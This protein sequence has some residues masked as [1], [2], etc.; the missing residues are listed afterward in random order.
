M[1]GHP[2]A[3]ETATWREA[4]LRVISKVGK[5][6]FC[7]DDLYAS[8]DDLSHLFPSNMNLEAKVRQQ[9]Q[10][11]RDEGLVDFIDNRGNY[12]LRRL[13]SVNRDLNDRI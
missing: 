9:L 7:L 6:S 12:R 3:G 4:I 11:L 2:D 1:S 8:L 5:E 10:Y 13:A